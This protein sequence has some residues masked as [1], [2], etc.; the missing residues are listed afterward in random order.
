MFKSCFAI[1]RRQHVAVRTF[2][3]GIPR[4]K[5]ILPRILPLETDSISDKTIDEWLDAV[6]HLRMNHEPRN[7][8]EAY[9]DQLAKPEPFLKHTFEPS[10]EQIA[11]LEALTNRPIPIK[12]DP[13]VQNL[14]NLIM[15]HGKKVKAQ[16]IVL[17]ALYIVYLKIRKDP[18]SILAET[19]D[20]LAPVVTT[21]TIITGHAK[22]QTV[23]VP[24]NQR[25][26]YRFAILW[27]LSGTE[28]KKSKN[29][30]VR[31]A[32]EIISAYEGKSSGYEK[33]ALMHKAAMQQRAYIK[34]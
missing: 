22:N 23:P 4:Y 7:E 26:R 15:R 32:D 9:L 12:E 27:I 5:S 14:T 3:S 30:L 10:A 29:M 25:Q 2:A 16:K 24:L 18:V 33:K 1:S 6:R 34:L 17:R 13:L 20:K 11:Q 21:K 28:T 8:T 31:L 19:L